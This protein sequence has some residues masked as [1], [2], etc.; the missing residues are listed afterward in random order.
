MA[1]RFVSLFILSVVRMIFVP[2]FRV[3]HC[4]I[5]DKQID[6]LFQCVHITALNDDEIV[7]R[8]ALK[9]DKLVGLSVEGRDGK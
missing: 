5:V 6:L 1:I 9:T 7:H 2:L 4:K 8:F 3:R